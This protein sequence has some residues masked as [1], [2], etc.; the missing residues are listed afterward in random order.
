MR[1]N[2]AISHMAHVRPT[3]STSVKVSAMKTSAIVIGLLLGL[4]FVAPR[5][6]AQ[7]AAP[8]GKALYTK[9]CRACHGP[10]GAPPAA[11]AKTMK[12][13]TIDAAYLAKVSDDSMV[14]LMTKGTKNMKPMKGKASPEEQAAIA[15]YIR[16]MVGSP[17]PKPGS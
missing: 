15:K 8:D 1:A 7:A 16:T 4:A 10:T 17:A 12:V 9:N 14:N 6:A 13:P 5:L 11:L 3:H 2:P